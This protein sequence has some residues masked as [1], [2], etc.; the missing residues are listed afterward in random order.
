MSRRSVGFLNGLGQIGQ[1]RLYFL[2]LPAE[3]K[4]EK[5][6]VHLKASARNDKGLKFLHKKPK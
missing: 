1:T 6:V 2:T 4:P 3:T 5:P